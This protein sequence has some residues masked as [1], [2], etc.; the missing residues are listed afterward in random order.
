MVIGQ[1]RS[2]LEDGASQPPL[3]HLKPDSPDAAQHILDHTT[4]RLPD[5]Q[6]FHQELDKAKG[7]STDLF[8][9][10]IFL[11][12]ELGELG[13]EV[14]Q[15]WKTHHRLAAGQNGDTKA[16]EQALTQHRRQLKSELSDCLAY[17]LKLANYT[18]IDLE[19]AYM[20]KMSLNLGRVWVDDKRLGKEDKN[21]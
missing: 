16:L 17:L 13:A 15:L 6:K 12:E 4:R 8:L 14:A 10:Y 11:T 3:P 20:E 21:R 7:F 19:A 5:F 18:G 1:I 9:N 2:T